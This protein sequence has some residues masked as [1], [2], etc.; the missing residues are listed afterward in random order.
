MY[1]ERLIEI[2]KVELK[3]ADGYKYVITAFEDITQIDYYAIENHKYE[4]KQT[5][6]L[7]SCHDI[8]IAEKIIE[9]RKAFKEE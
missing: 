7:S 2:N 4:L 3:S 5:Y 1:T 9:L 8:Q 6:D